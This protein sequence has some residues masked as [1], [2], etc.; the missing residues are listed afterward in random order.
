MKE[1]KKIIKISNKIDNKGFFKIADKIDDALAKKQII[2]PFN[3]SDIENEYSDNANFFIY[4]DYIPSRKNISGYEKQR[5]E[6]YNNLDINKKVPIIYI[7]PDLSSTLMD[8]VLSNNFLKNKKD[9]I[10]TTYNIKKSE[11][12]KDMLFMIGKINTGEAD[13]VDVVE[14]SIKKARENLNK[15]GYNSFISDLS[16]IIGDMARMDYDQIFLARDY[17]FHKTDII[18]DM[19]DLIPNKNKKSLI[20]N[21]FKKLNSDLSVLYK[22]DYSKNKISPFKDFIADYEDVKSIYPDNIG[23]VYLKIKKDAE[24]EHNPFKEELTF[25]PRDILLGNYENY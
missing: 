21:L 18:N 2:V 9:Y 19:I 22:A 14:Y 5:E 4:R 23:K 17:L 7:S 16:F 25:H 11:N 8:G 10:S 24:L 13:L 15:D 12:I 1:I 3:H 6:K 20:Y